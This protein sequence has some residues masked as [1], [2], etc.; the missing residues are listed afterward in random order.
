MY[1][2]LA[3]DIKNKFDRNN[4]NKVGPALGSGCAGWPLEVLYKTMM[5][6][7]WEIEL[8]L[9]VIPPGCLGQNSPLNFLPVNCKSYV[10]LS[11]CGHTETAA[12]NLYSDFDTATA[13]KHS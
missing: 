1:K 6:R 7:L 13:E 4:I 2:S 8:L 9:S 3:L 12:R 10:F 11:F 5:L